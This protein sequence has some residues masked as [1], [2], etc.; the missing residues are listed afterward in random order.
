MARAISATGARAGSSTIRSERENCAR[1]TAGSACILCRSRVENLA[2][3]PAGA[4]RAYKSAGSIRASQASS[5]LRKLF[6]MVAI[7]TISAK[8]ATMPA[9]PMA[10]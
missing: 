9:A 7:A 4:A 8:L 2:V 3:A 1:S 10:A 6:T 5:E